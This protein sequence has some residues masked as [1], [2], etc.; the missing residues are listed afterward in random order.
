MNPLRFDAKQHKY[1]VGDR[2]LISV[3]TL[4]KVMGLQWYPNN[5]AVRL[6]MELGSY[7]HQITEYYDKN[8]L[9][10]PVKFYPENIYKNDAI[11]KENGMHEA[12]PYFE[13][14]KKF[15][16]ETD[17]EVIEVEKRYYHPAWWYA[18]TIDRLVKLNGQLSI[19]DIKTGIPIPATALQI[20]GYAELYRHWHGVMPKGHV[21]YLQKDGS[22]KLKEIERIP[23]QANTFLSALSVHYWKQSNNIKEVNEYE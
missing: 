10:Y 21:L 22:Y 6:K 7:V 16:T 19:L 4:L 1:F 11:R 20:G 13:A 8:R 5:E 17:C 15:L 18:G 23:E 9:G 12:L 3:T 2:E 14:Y